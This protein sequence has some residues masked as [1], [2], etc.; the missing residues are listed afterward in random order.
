MINT[1]AKIAIR[2]LRI[3]WVIREGSLDDFRKVVYWNTCLW[4]GVRNYIFEDSSLPAQ[5]TLAK[6]YALDVI[7]YAEKP[8]EGLWP[9]GILE[10]ER[11]WSIIKCNHR[12][13]FE[14]HA[15]DVLPFLRSLGDEQKNVPEGR[16]S[17][18]SRFNF[19]KRDSFASLFI[20]KGHYPNPSESDIDYNKFAEAALGIQDIHISN[21]AALPKEYWLTPSFLAFT[22]CF[23]EDRGFGYSANRVV[24]LFGSTER[25]GDLIA[26][27]NMRATGSTIIFIDPTSIHRFED[28]VTAYIQDLCK[29]IRGNNFRPKIEY[30]RCESVTED[31]FNPAKA[32]V[33]ERF[34]QA[35]VDLTLFPFEIPKG[36]FSSR[37]STTPR[38]VLGVS[39]EQEGRSS[40]SFSLPSRPFD[41]QR[42]SYGHTF[43]VDIDHRSY[44]ENRCFST[45]FV[46]EL[47]E[48]FGRQQQYTGGYDRGRAT[49][50]GLSVL[51]HGTDEVV[52]IRSFDPRAFFIELFKKCSIQCS[53]RKSSHVVLQL[54]QRM[55][56]IEGFRAFKIEGVRKLVSKLKVDEPITRADATKIIF[57]NHQSEELKS[58]LLTEYADFGIKGKEPSSHGI[59]DQLVELDLFMPGLTIECPNCNLEAWIS[60]DDLKTISKCIFCGK[61]FHVGRAL[62]TAGA[63][64]YRK[65]GLLAR[66]DNQG[67][68]IP[69]GLILQSLNMNLDGDYGV[70]PYGVGFDLKDTDVDC[71]VDFACIHT[72]RGS[73]PALIIGEAKS[74]G[75]AIDQKDLS[76]LIAVAKR[77]ENVLKLKVYICIGKTGKFRPEE[78]EVIKAAKATFEDIIILSVDELEPLWCYS[79]KRGKDERLQSGRTLEA[80]V[81][82]S[83]IVHLT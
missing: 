63:W 2:P 53:I 69:V 14:A 51:C 33:E 29:R 27:W 31:S 3:A 38:D 46:P 35:K 16:L 13:K 47:N 23:L 39:L 50:F 48:F 5:E 59:F 32:M 41:P 11:G 52:T 54:I 49:P 57:G 9:N 56:G 64:K 62:K 6:E 42:V 1:V 4:G 24:F 79:S 55:G 15:I 45:P 61:K 43:A 75:G 34:K 10:F 30:L 58:R 17:K 72:D 22:G 80:L 40:L 78:I 68:G 20:C 76:N 8:A 65:S 21:G 44:D 60:L 74:Q 12:G 77:V 26:Y 28:S 18:L 7:S 37:Y 83:A 70:L 25:V 66:G 73:A 67:G 36:F 71:E 81:R 82:N 19:D